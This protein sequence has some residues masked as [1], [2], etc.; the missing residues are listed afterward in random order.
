MQITEKQ[1]KRLLAYA[2]LLI[3]KTKE[4]PVSYGTCGAIFIQASLENLKKEISD[5][6]E[7]LNT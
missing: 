3:D 6:N 4:D 1:Y 2:E 5:F 7:P